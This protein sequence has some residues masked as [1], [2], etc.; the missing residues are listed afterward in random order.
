MIDRGFLAK[1]N[2]TNIFTAGKTEDGSDPPP[3]A[4]PPPG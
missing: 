1:T 2:K 4:T 3:P